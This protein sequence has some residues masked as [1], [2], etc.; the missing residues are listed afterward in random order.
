LLIWM[1]RHAAK[2]LGERLGIAVLA[3]GTDFRTPPQGIPRCISPFDLGFIAHALLNLT[4]WTIVGF[5]GEY[6]AKKVFT[7][8]E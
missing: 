5:V 7:L 8:G 1:T 6:K 2:P 3:S 4:A